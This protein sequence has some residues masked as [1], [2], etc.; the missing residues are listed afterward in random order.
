MNPTNQWNVDKWYTVSVRSL[1]NLSTL[2]LETLKDLCQKQNKLCRLLIR[3]ED[4]FEKFEKSGNPMAS[5]PQLTQIS[6]IEEFQAFEERLV[7]G[8]TW[9]E[10]TDCKWLQIPKFFPYVIIC[11]ASE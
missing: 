1:T 5:G 11:V 10:I 6:S 7:I 8:N 4:R 3:L 9:G 2:L